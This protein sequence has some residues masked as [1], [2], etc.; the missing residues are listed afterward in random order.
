MDEGSLSFLENIISQQIYGVGGSD[1][2]YSYNLSTLR[3]PHPP[4]LSCSSVV[5]VPSGLGTL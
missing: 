1:S 3:H 4:S 2:F 5:D